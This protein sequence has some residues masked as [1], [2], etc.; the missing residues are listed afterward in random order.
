MKSIVHSA[1]IVLV[2]TALWAFTPLSAIPKSF[3]KL[4]GV[5]SPYA[6][7][8]F[9]SLF[10]F[11]L[12]IEN[13]IRGLSWP[14]VI[15]YLFITGH[16]L[17]VISLAL[18]ELLLPDGV[19]RLSDSFSTA[20]ALDFFITQL[21]FPFVLGGWLFAILGAISLKLMSKEHPGAA[22]VTR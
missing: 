21:L 17:S 3:M 5:A 1:I 20:G 10:G 13:R 16:L 22:K 11:L 14:K 18:A 12:L 4:P 8:F 9:A 6:A 7:V 2:L 15:F 19:Q